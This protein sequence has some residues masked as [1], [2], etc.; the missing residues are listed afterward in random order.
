MTVIDRD[1]G[2]AR[3]M[4]SIPELDG[5]HVLVGVFADDDRED[6]VEGT[7][8]DATN[9]DVAIFNEFGTSNGVPERSFLRSTVDAKQDKYAKVLADGVG[10]HLDGKV[11]IDKALDL[12]GLVAVGDVQTTIRDLDTPENTEATIARKGSSNPLIDTG[13]L[14]QAI[15]HEVRRGGTNIAGGV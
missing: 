7:G 8:S 3:I 15:A 1:L 11:S 2:Y 6:P 13:Q 5:V 4:R 10:R 12:L 9:A 14:R